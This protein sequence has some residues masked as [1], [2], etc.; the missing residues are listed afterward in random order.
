VVP[1]NA[2]YYVVQVPLN[3]SGSRV[4]EYTLSHAEYEQ[5]EKAR[6]AALTETE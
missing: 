1:T 6:E 5:W 4:Q 3:R 2:T